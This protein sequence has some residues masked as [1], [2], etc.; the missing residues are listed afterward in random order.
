MEQNKAYDFVGSLQD[1]IE[2]LKTKLKY[3]QIYQNIWDNIPYLP[4]ELV[5]TGDRELP[6]ILTSGTKTSQFHWLCLESDTLTQAM[7][8]YNQMLAKGHIVDDLYLLP[9]K[10]IKLST[11]KE[12][13]DITKCRKIA[14]YWIDVSKWEARLKFYLKLKDGSQIC[15]WITV[16]NGVRLAWESKAELGYTV[17]LNSRAIIDP[18]NKEYF[19]NNCRFSSGSSDVPASIQL[20][21]DI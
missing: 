13:T 21:K 8:F 15:L 5:K 2:S 4:P 1:D 18:N 14:P 16:N 17:A 19:T 10:W 11:D 7:E 6:K 20:W 9:Q 3:L 12:I